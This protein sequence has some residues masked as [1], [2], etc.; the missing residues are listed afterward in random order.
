MGPFFDDWGAVIATHPSLSAADRSEVI[1]ALVSGHESD[2][3]QSGY[4]RALNGIHANVRGGIERAAKELPAKQLRLIAA[5]P[6]REGLGLTRE[7]FD[8]RTAKRA[9]DLLKTLV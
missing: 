6:I 9:R 7:R 5:G 4:L 1:D 3:L 2:P 8:A